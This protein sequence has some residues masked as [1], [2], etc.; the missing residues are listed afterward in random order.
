VSNKFIKA[1]LYTYTRV[2]CKAS[3]SHFAQWASNLIAYNHQ[4]FSMPLGY[5]RVVNNKF[6]GC[7]GECLLVLTLFGARAT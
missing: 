6:E 4:R 2:R 7:G 5:S 3:A 1:L